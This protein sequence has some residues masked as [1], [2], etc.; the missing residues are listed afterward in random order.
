M[1]DSSCTSVLRLPS[2]T[3]PTAMATLVSRT[4]PSGIIPIIAATEDGTA[5]FT[6]M[7]FSS[8]CFRNSRTPSGISTMES[9]RISFL[10]SA[11]RRDSGRASFLASAVSRPA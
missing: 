3:T 1:P 11:I 9:K 5:S 7:W 8:T 2:F 10:M 6:A 4:S